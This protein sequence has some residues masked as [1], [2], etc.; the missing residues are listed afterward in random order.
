MIAASFSKLFHEL[1]VCAVLLAQELQRDGAVEARVE[2]P[3]NRAHAAGAEDFLEFEMIE[4]APDPLGAAA[5]GAMHQRE[6]LL[7]GNID[8]RAAITTGLDQGLFLR[9]HW[10]RRLPPRQPSGNMSRV[11]LTSH[12]EKCATARIFVPMIKT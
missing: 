7:V 8:Q 4:V 1:L 9:G 6:R 3:I 5:R 12:S 10:V 2:R 11:R